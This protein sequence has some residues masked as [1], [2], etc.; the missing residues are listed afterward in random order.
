MTLIQTEFKTEHIVDRFNRGTLILKISMDKKDW[1]NI[2]DKVYIEVESNYP[3]ID[4]HLDEKTIKPV[5]T[6]GL[7]FLKEDL[8]SVP[9]K[10]VTVED[11]DMKINIAGRKFRNVNYLSGTSWSIKNDKAYIKFFLRDK[12]GVYSWKK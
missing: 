5:D 8:L 7:F 10:K 11:Y 1:L 12:S 6:Q 9:H 2:K 4:I 3:S